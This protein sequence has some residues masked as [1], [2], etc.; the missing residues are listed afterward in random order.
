MSSTLSKIPISSEMLELN[1]IL[2]E[3]LNC[4]CNNGVKYPFL[5]SAIS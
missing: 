1:I 4:N 5:S 2:S 3:N